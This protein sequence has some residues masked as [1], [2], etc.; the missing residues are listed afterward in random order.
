MKGIIKQ[1]IIK[2]IKIKFI[3]HRGEQGKGA[4]QISPAGAPAKHGI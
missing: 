1:A 2:C 4:F 3:N